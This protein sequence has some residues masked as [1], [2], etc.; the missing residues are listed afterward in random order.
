MARATTWSR[1][2]GSPGFAAEGRGGGSV[3]WAPISAPFELRGNGTS[4]VRVSYRTHPSEY[5]SALP[6]IVVSSNISGAA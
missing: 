1:A 4:P 2:G 3:R 5:W 6:S